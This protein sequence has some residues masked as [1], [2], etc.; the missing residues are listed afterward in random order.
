M[1]KILIVISVLFI[2]WNAEAT[3]ILYGNNI[4]IIEP[5]YEDVYI[6]AGSVTINA[7]IYGDLIMAGGQVF[8]N[9]HVRNDVL[10]AGGEIFINGHVGDDLRCA[11]GEVTIQKDITGDL[12]ITGGTVTIEKQVTIHGTLLSSGGAVIVHGNVNGDIKAAAGTFTLNGVA[13]GALE[14]RSSTVNIN[15]EVRGPAVLSAIT[16]NVGKAASFANDVRYYSAKGK[17]NF[18]SALKGVTATYDPALRIESAKWYFLGSASLV[19][20][21]LFSG[22]ILLLIMVLQYLFG[23]TFS[24]A[25]DMVY[26]STVKSLGAGALFFVAVPVAI[27]LTF[28]TVIAIPVSIFLLLSYIMLIMLATTITSVV[29]ANW[30]NSRSQLKWNYWKLVAGSFGMFVL[31]KLISLT[32]LYG[33]PMAILLVCIGFGSIILSINWKPRKLVSEQTLKTAA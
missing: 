33:P 9:N 23:R 4:R 28:L 11:G 20:M 5:V 15:G 1:K 32:P 10:V 19:G 31:I 8:L 24:Y 30:L 2:E 16:L 29:A 14:T 21:L 18:A 26:T 13:L 6:A 22:M 12:V 27:L 7:P 25:S 3:K 17:V